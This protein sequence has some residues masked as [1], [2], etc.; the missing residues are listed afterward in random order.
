M[1]KK[2][3]ISE[4]KKTIVS[5]VSW[6]LAGK[7][8]NLISALLVGIFVA[9]YLGPERYG[10]MNY[11]I[12]FVNLFLILATFGFENIEIREESKHEQEK[13]AIIGT[14]F[15]LR[16]L[17]SIL[18][19]VIIMAVAFFKEADRE[20]MTL[21]FIYSIS[22]LMTP[23]D[24]IRNYF[25]SIVQNEYIVK[26]GI[27]RT[28]CSGLIKITLLLL[29]APLILFVVALTFDAI[30]MAEGYIFVYRKKIG[31]IKNWKFSREWAS[32][33]IRQS[34]PLLLSGAA[35]TIF[36]QIDQVMIGDMI[37]DNKSS[38]AYFSI[39]SKIVEILLYVPT[40]IIQ[41]VCPI[42]VRIKQED[43]TRYQQQSQQFMNITVWL[44]VLVAIVMS[45]TA[46]W[47]VTLTFGQ[48]YVQA[49][50]PLQ[51]LSFKVIAVALNIISGQ[52]LI[53][54]RNQ[55]YFVL[56]SF[57]GCVACVL[58]NLVVIP[59]YGIV[60]VAYVAIITQVVAGFL[61]HAI[62]PPYRYIFKMQLRTLTGGWR[63]IVHIRKLIGGQ[64]A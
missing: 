55:K 8:T 29:K 14:T 11:V 58:L 27:A 32:I 3:S 53:I 54:D 19:I 6:A 25:T 9:R 64:T 1:L 26:V 46:Y 48:K 2:N 60:G 21:I 22:V 34:F 43:E 37:K 56:R 50:F 57:S 63:D 62:I 24:V 33:M 44:C 20:T 15:A 30:I 4:N 7:I 12:S 16:F 61:I 18:T 35:A 52:L 38:V 28:V 59:R 36:L 17:F 5:N 51:V 41:V 40:I 45:L 13:D 23:F 10:L 42:L 49:V 31:R 39:A 47:C